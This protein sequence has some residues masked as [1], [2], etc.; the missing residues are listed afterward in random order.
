VGKATGTIIQLIQV[1]IYFHFWAT[2]VY[3][4]WLIISAI[5]T[6]LTFTSAGFG[7]VAANEMTMLMAG[8]DREGALRVFQSCWW[9]IAFIGMAIGLLLVP[10]LYFVPVADLLN[11]HAISA[12]DTKR[13]IFYLAGSVLLGQLEWLM[14]AA[15]TCVARYPYG[16]FL[17]NM[18]TLAAFAATMVPVVL[19][20]GPRTAALVFAVANTLGTV[21]FGLFVRHDM[22]WIEFGWKHARWSEIRRMTVPAFAFMGFPIGN[23]LNLQGTL[24]AVG[25]ALGPVEVAI[26]ASA[27]TVSRVALQM[28]QLVNN[29]VW[30]ELS[31]AYGA[32]NYDLLR[33]LH[34]RACQMALIFSAF[35]VLSMMSFGPW[36]LTHWT[37][38][39]VPPSRGLLAILLLVVLIYSLWSTS[40]TLAT[41]INQHQRLA[42]WYIVGTGVTVGFT[43]VLAR[44]YGLYGAAGSL[45]LSEV[46]MNLYVL[47][48]SL[49]IAHD[50]FP[51]FCASLLQY[52]ESL[53]PAALLSRLSRSK[54][55]LEAE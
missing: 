53:K 37:G 16:T 22:P 23:A 33:S 35:I 44:R 18:I 54:P 51:A 7:S 15:Y 32:R 12:V 8:G 26:F 46:I 11:S 25:Y 17:K 47:P 48:A 30:P 36:F 29:T 49:R 5:P 28:V 9:L 27:R 39:H 6:Q 24:V 38:G 21:V 10:V 55:T 43:Y 19:G 50:T 13:I 41:A 2:T 4:D 45:I 1:P 52:P 31:L 40:S 14:G 34:R 20:Y 3:G 42:M